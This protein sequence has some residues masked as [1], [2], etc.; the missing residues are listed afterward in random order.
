MEGYSR[1]TK[2]LS[3]FVSTEG[4]QIFDPENLCF[5]TEQQRPLQSSNIWLNTP[6]QANTV[7]YN[8]PCN[9]NVRFTTERFLNSISETVLSG[10]N[11]WII[12]LIIVIDCECGTRERTV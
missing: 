9:N 5:D 4:E 10:A 8:S 7:Q 1:I 3:A 2:Q 11:Y 12:I 6:V